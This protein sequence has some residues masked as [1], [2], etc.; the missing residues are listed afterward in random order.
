VQVN[1]RQRENDVTVVFTGLAVGAV[2]AFVAIG[3]NLTL[4]GSG[5]LNFAFADI[6]LLGSFISSAILTTDQIPIVLVL[7]LTTAIGAVLG[8]AE[9]R[10]A[11]RLLIPGTHGELVTTVGIGT[12][13]TGVIVAVYGTNARVVLNDLPQLS[14]FGGNTTSPAVIMLFGTIALAVAIHLWLSR[15]RLGLAA[16]ARSEDPEAAT[17]MGIN[18]RRMSLI[19]FAFAGGLAGLAGAP[20]GSLMGVNIGV[21]LLIAIKGFVAMTIGG[22]RSMGGAVIGGLTVGLAESFAD[23]YIGG[24]YQDL[25]T[26]LLFVLIVLAKPSGLLGQT[27]GRTV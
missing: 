25:V 1:F 11:I 14:I 6:I 2:Y 21:A 5:V 15:S 3:Y 16:L 13:I 4:I 8:A 7:L 20:V 27:E 17:L 9:E 18:V 23:R 22:M 26:F 24:E 19:A 12:L 10:F